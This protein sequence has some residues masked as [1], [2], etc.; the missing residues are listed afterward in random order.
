MSKFSQ[1]DEDGNELNLRE[2]EMENWM[3]LLNLKNDDIELLR[4]KL[5]VDPMPKGGKINNDIDL[6]LLQDLFNKAYSHEKTDNRNTDSEA[7]TAKPFMKLFDTKP[8]AN[9][10]HSL[11]VD[12]IDGDK[13]DDLLIGA[14]GKKF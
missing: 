3:S 10:G 14:P 4:S 6:S 9:I 7:E 11:H 1:K 8:Y 5:K 13:K 2:N 12:D